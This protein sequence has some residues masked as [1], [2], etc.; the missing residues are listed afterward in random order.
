M[1]KLILFFVAAITVSSFSACNRNYTCQCNNVVTG[2]V[3]VG[4]IMAST[5]R[6]AAEHCQISDADSRKYYECRIR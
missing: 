5:A 1:K 6:D 2:E 4:N 3:L